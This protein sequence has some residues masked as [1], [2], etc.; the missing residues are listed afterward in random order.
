MRAM[1]PGALDVKTSLGGI[2]RNPLGG[3]DLGNA[4]H[5][6]DLDSVGVASL[7]NTPPREYRF[8]SRAR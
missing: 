6:Q 8:F 4:P 5:G 3:N 2:P 7:G 1:C